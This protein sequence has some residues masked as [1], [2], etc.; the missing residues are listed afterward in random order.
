M[1]AVA[2]SNNEP[3]DPALFRR[4]R[5]IVYE[6]AG[7]HLRDGKEALVKARLSKRLRALGLPNLRKYLDFLHRDESGQELVQLLDVI[8]TNF[9]SFFREREHFELLS[10]TLKR[11]RANGQ[12]RF[13]LWSAASSSGEEPYSMAIA[14]SLGLDDEAVDY[15]ILA[16]DISTS[17]LARAEQA[18]Y[19]EKTLAPV[20]KVERTRGFRRHRIG[21]ETHWQVRREVKA[22]VLLRRLNLAQPP[23][24]MKGPLDIIFCRNVMIYFDRPVRQALV[25]EMERLL[26]ENGLLVIGHAETLTGLDTGLRM[27]TPSVYRRETI[28]TGSRPR[29]R[30]G[31]RAREPR[32]RR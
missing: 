22:R 21:T 8:S 12:R 20:T 23:F 7:I 4:F 25:A 18:I 32:N 17:V 15:Q 6:N 10:D 13:R 16:T 27:V 1:L 11:L 19:P 31:L 28:Q 9:T 24:P 14:A 5:R 3:M 30:R 2:T 29:R 26:P